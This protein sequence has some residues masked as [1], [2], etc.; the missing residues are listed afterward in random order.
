MDIQI[1]IIT[2]ILQ[3]IQYRNKELLLNL[4]KAELII[5]GGYLTELAMMVNPKKYHSIHKLFN[6][7]RFD[8]IAIQIEIIMA[9][10]LFFKIA[11]IS[12]SIDDSIVYRSRKKKVP[13]GDKQFDHAKK[14]NRSSF[15]FG[16][17]WLAFGLIITIGGVA[18][19]I[20]LFIYLVEPKKNLISTTVIILA[21]IKRVMDKRGLEIEV[22]IITDSWFAR[23]KLIL[24]AKQ[25]YGFSVI[26]MARKDLALYYLP[27]FRR[28]KTKGRP[29]KKG[30]RIKPELKDLK[31]ERR[32]HIYNREVKIQYKEAIC[33]AKF[34]KYERVKAV[35]V[36]FDES[37]S[38]H[39]IIS[40]NEKLSGEEIIKRYAKRWDIEPMFNELKN[41]F[42]FKDIMMH[43]TQSYY[44]FLYFKIWCFIIIKLSSIHFK[45][46]IIDYIKEML[47]WRVHHEK[48][49]VVT[50][51][52]TK[53]ALRRVFSTL[54][55][56]LFFPKVY[57]NIGGD[58]VN[59][60]FMG[61]GLGGEY[62][63][64]G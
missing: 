2:I 40:T 64:T 28:R 14:A 34:L 25:K 10:V 17:K 16:Q 63:L 45:K 30:K 22:E 21:K 27:P 53:L 61:F 12:I 8:Y 39:L 36:R 24:R 58:Y 33:K 5:S 52:S 29:K 23:E 7:A 11:K 9:I 46:Q 44:Q 1:R 38:M 3:S 37:K 57:K 55:I 56:G 42:R 15:V 59:I 47:P 18:I 32:V 43:T 50:A 62:D 13:H 19:T 4:I 60:D 31:K 54:H 6:R 26:T 35:W 49:V 20:P 48:G 51:G 41:Y